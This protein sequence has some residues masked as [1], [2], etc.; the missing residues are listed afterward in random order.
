MSIHATPGVCSPQRIAALRVDA[1]ARRCALLVNAR[2]LAA[3]DDG[4]LR[5]LAE[6]HADRSGRD[7]AR[8]LVAAALA[9]TPWSLAMGRD[10]DAVIRAFIAATRR[11]AFAA[12]QLDRPLARLREVAAQAQAMIAAEEALTALAPREMAELRRRWR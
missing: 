5:R 8:R 6:R 3:A 1:V 12:A 10:L 11:G 2:I 9:E 7:A 4:A